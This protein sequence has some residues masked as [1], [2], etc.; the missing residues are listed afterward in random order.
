M[1]LRYLAA[2]PVLLFVIIRSMKKPKEG[3]LWFLVVLYCTPSSF[4]WGFEQ[5]HIPLF[6]AVCILI[7]TVF[8]FNQIN[9]QPLRMNLL[10]FFWAILF[11]G[12]LLST[13][14]SLN[15]SRSVNILLNK[16]IKT[17]LF[18]LLLVCWTENMEDVKRIFYVTIG[19]FTLLALRGIYRYFVGYTEIGGAA[20]SMMDRNDFAL[21]LMMVVPIAYYL[22]ENLP[23][24]FKKVL[25]L[26][27]SAIL[28]TCVIVTFSRMGF[29]LVLTGCCLMFIISKKK[30]QWI[31]ASGLVFF[32]LYHFMPESYFERLRTIA[33]YEQDASAMGRI[34]AWKAG[35]AMGL[36]RPFTGVGLDCFELPSVYLRY[37]V[38]EIPHVAHN[39]YVQIFAEAGIPG[40]IGWLGLVI[41]MLFKNIKLYRSC[42]TITKRYLALSLSF[43]VIFY[44]IGSVFLS[45]E[46]REMIY[47]FAGLTRVLESLS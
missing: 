38:D 40:L 10:F 2:F 5:W 20:G 22:S 11:V 16:W 19:C 36:D 39:A 35:I 31:I 13:A 18:V 45:V 21:H 30:L 1:P 32:F 33:H 12:L 41:T 44:L 8:H 28:M 9:N 25:F 27:A 7:S 26:S 15:I 42:N 46:D 14:N 4:F 6:I 3:I 37:S 24:K 43:S 34:N 17:F 29:I 47:I 23:G